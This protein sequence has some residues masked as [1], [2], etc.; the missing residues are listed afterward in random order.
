MFLWS[1]RSFYSILILII[2]FC[3]AADL[4]AGSA[5]PTKTT[6]SNGLAVVL[7]EDHS[8]PVVAFQMWV[9]VGSADEEKEEAGI[10]H[11]F[12]HM[13][14]KGTGKRG[15]G[16]IA[17]EVEG[18]GGYINA[19]T[20]Y[21]QT[22][23]H[24]A[25]ASRYFDRGLDVISDAIQNSTFDADELRK[26]LEVVLEEVRMGEDNSRRRLFK[27]LV[28]ASYMTH[29]YGKPVIG[30]VES[31]KA[32]T[33]DKILDFFRK[34]YVPGNMTLFVVGD[35][36]SGEALRKIKTAFR[37]F[38][39]SNDII[40][41]RPVE[42]PQDGLRVVHSAMDIKGTKLGMAFHI[43]ELGNPDVFA[44]DV[45]SEI[46]SNGRTSRLYRRLK[47]KERTVHSVS[48][49]AMT[50]QDPGLFIVN[51]DLDVENLEEAVGSIIDEL[52]KI[53]GRGVSWAELERA[54]LSLESE[55]I[56]ERETMDGR[57]RQ[58]GYFDVIAGDLEFEDRYLNGISRVTSRDIKEAAGKYLSRDNMT[59]ALVLPKEDAK[60]VDDAGIE[61]LVDSSFKVSTALYRAEDDGKDIERLKLDNGITLIVKEDY[62]NPTVAVYLTFPGGL[63]FEGE[64]TNGLGNFV[65]SLLNRGT[66]TRDAGAFAR[67]VEDIAA[68]ISGFSGRNSI[69]MSASFLSRYFDRGMDLLA[70]AILNPAFHEGEIEKVRGDIIAAIEREE[71]YLPGYT[72]KLLYRA[73]YKSHPY[74]M[75][76][77]G[78][79]EIVEGIDREDI[80]EHYERLIAPDRMVMV[81]A[82][83]VEKEVAI[84]KVKELFGGF[85]RKAPGLQGPPP[86]ERQAVK[87]VTGARKSSNQVNIGIGFLGTTIAADDRYALAVLTKI[88]SAQGGRLFSNL[89]DKRSLAYS[90][91]AFSRL[92]VEPGTFAVY[93]GTA[94]DKM[95]AAIDGVLDELAKVVNGRVTGEELERAKSAIIGGYEM[96]L[97]SNR[98]Q[99]ADMANNELFGLGY[100]E[101]RRYPGKIEGVTADDVLEVAER[102]ITLDAYTIS[103]VGPDVGVRESE[104]PVEGKATP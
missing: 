42:P 77:K 26:E 81:V 94:P 16:G 63:R 93:I 17:R 11:V 41:E 36:D 83:A 44:L 49:Y 30:T 69:G 64:K 88:L 104:V 9:K 13:L 21:D 91:S 70:D 58:L 53:K 5:G 87:R 12:E 62:S 72:F 38:K 79:K 33:R 67:D 74:G 85:D 56:F 10:A 14:F 6:L 43:P 57:A 90:V 50:P 65:A 99:A 1:R 89:R 31:V 78:T 18:A 80:V 7:E 52:E 8:A 54:K 102:Y 86:E 27:E 97:Q 24:L 48:A 103:I 15:V 66:V 60:A 4:F 101:F 25:I 29:P 84:A 59:I 20:S 39:G 35:F 61:E 95:K 32:L 71:N 47:D 100:D 28:S 45:M 3:A 75:P 73:L 37:D 34:W 68:T 19:F 23:Y 92:G 46:L 2:L 51:A 98:S 55:F 22:V 96:G 76:L 40:R 82:G